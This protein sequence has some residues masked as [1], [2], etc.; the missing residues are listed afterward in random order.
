MTILSKYYYTCLSQIYKYEAFFVHK[1]GLV[2]KK[3]IKLCK[4]ANI[5]GTILLE[6]WNIKLELQVYFRRY[7][8]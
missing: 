3:I 7:K 2:I 8:Q 5:Y 1:K 6:F 4:M